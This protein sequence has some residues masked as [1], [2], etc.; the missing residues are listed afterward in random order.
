MEFDAL[1][2]GGGII[3]M[4]SAIQLSKEGMRIAVID[5]GE[6]GNEA[7]WAAGGIL[8][9]LHPWEQNEDCLC[10]AQR[11]E[12]LFPEFAK[13][14]TEETKID[15]Q[16]IQSGMIN[17]DAKP[18]QSSQWLNENKHKCENVSNKQLKKYEPH[19]D[20]NSEH[21]LYLPS[22]MQ[23]R[24][25]QLLQ[26]L[27]AYLKILGVSVFKQSEV[28]RLITQ[29]NIVQGI[30]TT[31]IKLHSEK[32]IVCSGAWTGELLR[33]NDIHDTD[34]QPVRGQMLLYPAQD[35]RINHIVV[36]QGRYIIPRQDGQLLCGSTIEDVGFNQETTAQAA[37][38]L[39][40]F[41]Q[42]L[43]P[44]LMQNTATHHWAALRPAT[45]RKAPYICEHPKLSG[46]YFNTGHFRYGITMSLASAEI[47]RKLIMHKLP[48]SQ[49]ES[50]AY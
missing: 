48:A 29:T 2:I 50:Y 23:I 22:V 49:I 42:S 28:R 12:E 45:Q 38:E 6:L 40:Q 14:L 9:P 37:H 36:S 30:E 11:S 43:F 15:P 31:T 41:A 18:Q 26:A 3:G 27:K 8:S 21:A 39:D 25:P 4:T 32:V 16:L 7:S 10:L 1:I 5:K 46:L 33:Q 44:H 34:V 24:P 47:L 13:T 20:T 17:L 19:L 35:K